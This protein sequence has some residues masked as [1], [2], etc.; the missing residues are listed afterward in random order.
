MSLKIKDVYNV[1]LRKVP[2]FAKGRK[3]IH[4]KGKKAY[5]KMSAVFISR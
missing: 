2:N 1:Y 3:Y 4:M 5:I